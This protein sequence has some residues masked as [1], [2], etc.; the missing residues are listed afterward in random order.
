MNA[1]STRNIALAAFLVTGRHLKLNH[2]EMDGAIGLFVFDDEKQQ[3]DELEAAFL[4]QDAVVPASQ[5]Y[6]TIRT[7]RR[8]IDE[9]KYA[10]NSNHIRGY[11]HARDYAHR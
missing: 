3:G 2:L 1:F 10:Q 6:R 8:M 11:E 9:R 5:F 4:T 7:L